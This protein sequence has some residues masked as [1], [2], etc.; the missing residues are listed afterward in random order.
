MHHGLLPALACM[1][2]G[3]H[4]ILVGQI[5]IGLGIDQGLDD[6]L[7]ARPAVAEHH[8]FHQAGP[9]QPVDMV[10]IH[11]GGDQRLGRFQMAALAGRNQGRAA[12][13]V[14][15]L[16]IGA[17]GNRH[18]HNLQPALRAGQQIGAV[19]HLVLDIGAG[20]VHQQRSRHLDMVGRRGQQQRG[21]APGVLHATGA[22]PASRLRTATAS[23]CAVAGPASSPAPQ[24]RQVLQPEHSPTPYSGRP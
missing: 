5:Q 18:A 10:H 9:A 7:M 14:G 17:I 3:R 16:E 22:L 15:A 11:A 20:T 12:I 1:G 21:I 6:G 4:P 2:Q 24:R 23:P 13:A 8:G 19:L